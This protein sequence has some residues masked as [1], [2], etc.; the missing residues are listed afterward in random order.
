[1]PA[2]QFPATPVPQMAPIKTSFNLVYSDVLTIGNTTQNSN[3]ITSTVT[4]PI[5]STVALIRETRSTISGV[6]SYTSYLS[7]AIYSTT[8]AVDT[9]I[10]TTAPSWYAPAMPRPMADVGYQFEIMAGD[11]RKRYS[12][13]TWAAWVANVIAVPIQFAKSLLP[14]AQIM[15]PFGLFLGWLFVM[16]P[17]VLMFRTLEFLKTMVIRVFNFIWDVI[18]FIGDIWDMIPF[19]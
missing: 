5:S 3:T 13:A 9:I 1:M 16:A 17:V 18:K 11:L 19:A 15:G 10:T 2:I 8:L 7:K 6:I 14:F 4:G 12:I